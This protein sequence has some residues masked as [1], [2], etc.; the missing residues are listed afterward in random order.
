[1]CLRFLVHMGVVVGRERMRL[2]REVSMGD[3]T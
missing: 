2:L 1:M 3:E